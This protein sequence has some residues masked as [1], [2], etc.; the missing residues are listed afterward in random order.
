MLW[1]EE[2][3]LGIDIAVTLLGPT[4]AE[5]IQ[6]ATAESMPPDKPRTTFLIPL[7]AQ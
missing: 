6:A 5:A 2:W 7:L 1:S 3:R 4:A